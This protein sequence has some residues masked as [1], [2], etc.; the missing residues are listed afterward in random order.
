VQQSK[1]KE[2]IKL[3]KSNRKISIPT[4]TQK[5]GT[6]VCLH[7]LWFKKKTQKNVTQDLGVFSMWWP[8]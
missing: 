6:S 8:S 4:Y 7:E 1:Q 5:E 3:S 2:K